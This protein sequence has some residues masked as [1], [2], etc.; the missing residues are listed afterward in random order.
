MKG[1]DNLGE[2]FR[3]CIAIQTL[4]FAI[5]IG[6][7]LCQHRTLTDHSHVFVLHRRLFQT[8]VGAYMSLGLAGNHHTH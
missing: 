8:K 1:V 5:I 6:R 4:F 3:Y 7:P 2:E